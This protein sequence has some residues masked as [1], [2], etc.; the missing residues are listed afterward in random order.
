M[1]NGI[2][3]LSREFLKRK[4]G[5]E[6]IRFNGDSLNTE[7]LFRT[8]HSVNRLSI[9]GAV[10]NWSEQFGLTEEHK[11]RGNRRSVNKNFWTIVKSHEVQL[12]V[13]PPKSGICK[14]FA[15]KHFEV[16]MFAKTLGLNIVSAG[17]MYKT[18][19]DEDDG[20]GQLVPFC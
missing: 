15:R 11:G 1:F 19:L 12:L 20:Y 14:Q 3:A 17:M 4:K 6:T 5:K 2:S 18:R 9:C 7:L 8:T 13:S 10:A 16:Q